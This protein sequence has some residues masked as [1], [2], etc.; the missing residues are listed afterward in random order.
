LL[1]RAFIMAAACHQDVAQG[2]LKA[3]ARQSVTKRDR[4]REPDLLPMHSFDADPAFDHEADLLESDRVRSLI[5]VGMVFITAC[6]AL[7]VTNLFG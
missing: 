4:R 5:I 6:A 2:G 1:R 3:L 7:G